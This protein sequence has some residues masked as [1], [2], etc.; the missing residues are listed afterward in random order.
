MSNKVFVGGIP[1][2]M[3][4]DRLREVFAEFGTIT[5][6][7]VIMDR[8]KGQSRGF[9]FVEFE[10]RGA[11]QEAIDRLDGTKLDGRKVTV[12]EAQDRQRDDQRGGGGGG[13]R[14]EH[15]NRRTR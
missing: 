5:S 6:A 2:A 9:G 4:D 3:D 15:S 12:N 8:E 14:R 13:A 7:K 1:W 10:D 11:M